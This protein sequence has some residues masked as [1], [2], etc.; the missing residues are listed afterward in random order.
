MQ[1][2]KFAKTMWPDGLRGEGVWIAAVSGV[3]IQIIEPGHEEFSQDSE[4][5]GHEFNK[6]GTN[7]ELGIRTSLG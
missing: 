3:R 4:L 5:F 2:L 7:C 1:R 6:A